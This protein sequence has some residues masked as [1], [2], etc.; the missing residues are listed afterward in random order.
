[1]KTLAQTTQ[2]TKATPEAIFAL[3][4]NVDSWADY[5]QGIEWAK[6]TDTF[7]AGGHYT[8]KPKGG[9]KVSATILVAD[10]GKRFID[11]S[12]LPGAKLTFDHEIMQQDGATTVRVTMTIDGP[13]SFMWAKI[14]GK[15]Q[16]AD[17]ETSTAHLIEKAEGNA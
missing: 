17:L 13:M 14:L 9:P 10:P 3:W 15:N 12:T 1:M 6:L 8:L 2:T 16:Q 11:V 4:A 5:D 7:T